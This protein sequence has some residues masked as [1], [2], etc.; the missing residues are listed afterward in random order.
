MTEIHPVKILTPL[1]V[2]FF[3]ISCKSPQCKNKNVVFDKF[4]P[5]SR[6]Y[7]EELIKQ[8]GAVD[9]SKINFLFHECFSTNGKN[10]LIF[11]VRSD[12]LCANAILLI[13]SWTGIEN[14]EKTKG[15]GYRGA[16]FKNLKFD[17][18]RD[19]LQTELVFKSADKIF[20]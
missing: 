3:V 12:S 13:R 8:L 5:S 7:K 1:F 11:F 10:Y 15:K 2:L 14:I 20:D 18:Y 17:I 19:S 9:H 6:D 16:E 4:G